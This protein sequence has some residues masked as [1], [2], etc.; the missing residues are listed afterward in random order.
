MLFPNLKGRQKL[1]QAWGSPKPQPCK[2]KDDLY[3]CLPVHPRRFHAQSWSEALM[4][5][6]FQASKSHLHIG[7]KLTPEPTADLAYLSTSHSTH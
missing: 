6:T 7:Y 3:E 4:K 2:A 1:K 5:T